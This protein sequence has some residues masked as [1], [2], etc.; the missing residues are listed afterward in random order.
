MPKVLVVDDEA[1]IRDLVSVY[2]SAAGFEVGQAADGAAALE[3]VLAEPYD[4]VILDIM[5]PGIDGAEVCRSIRKRSTVPI[6]MLTARADELEKISLLEDGADDYVTKPF[7]PPE[8][9]ARVRAVMRRTAAADGAEHV[10]VH[11]G[12]WLDTARR[13]TKVDGQEVVLTAKEF[14]LLVTML[15]DPGVVFSRERLLEAVWGFS[16]FVDLRGVDVHI[17]HLREKLGDDAA[18]PRFIET[19]RGVGYRVRKDGG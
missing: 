17:R 12:L 9:V 16:D 1:K 11:G 4:I 18:A 8:L 13:E 7:S 5:L 6:I 15:R 2:L 14:D 10:H 3:A 19:V